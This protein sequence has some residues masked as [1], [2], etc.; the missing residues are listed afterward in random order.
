MAKKAEINKSEVIRELYKSGMTKTSDIAAELEKRGIKVSKPMI[1]TTIST[2]R[3]KEGAVAVAPEPEL[4]VNQQEVVVATSAVDT[5]RGLATKLGGY[6]RLRDL[7]D[8][9]VTLDG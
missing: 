5:L 8:M 2:L 3:K 7:V 9:L 1:Y 4:G 6:S